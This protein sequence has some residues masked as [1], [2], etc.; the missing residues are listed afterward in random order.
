[1]AAEPRPLRRDAQRNRELLL[2]AAR[3]VFGEKGLDAPLEEIARK[4]G[5]AI[6]TL[7][8]RFPSRTALIEEIFAEVIEKWAEIGEEALKFED[9]W[10]GFTHFVERTC[11]MQ[12]VDRGLSEVC[13]MTFPGVP[14]IDRAKSQV[15]EV[16]G[17][18]IGRAHEEGGLRADFTAEDLIVAVVSTSR[19]GEF[20]LG[21]WR[22][23]L[24]FL[25]DGCRVQ[26]P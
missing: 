25:L 5:V 4:A 13:V 6:G 18:V 3:D 16:L 21:D 9:A 20:S 24:G 12:S 1:M 8:N 2:A 23:H 15:W 17:R 19:V 26:A 11:E 14:R 10:E 7:Y 22:R